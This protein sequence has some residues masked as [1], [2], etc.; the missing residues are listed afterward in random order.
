MKELVQLSGSFL[1]S[2]VYFSNKLFVVQP[3]TCMFVTLGMARIQM[4][5]RLCVIEIIEVHSYNYYI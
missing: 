4:Y 1:K 3:R 5:I 2:T